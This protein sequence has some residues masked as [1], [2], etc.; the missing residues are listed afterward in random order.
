M[1]INANYKPMAYVSDGVS[2]T[3]YINFV[4]FNDE[5]EAVNEDGIKY[6]N[7]TIIRN[8][9]GKG[10]IVFGAPLEK[11]TKV[12]IRRSVPLVQSVTFN[13]GGNFPADDFEFSLDRIY[14]ILQG[15]GYDISRSI[16]L[17]EKYKDFE[18]FDKNIV[19]FPFNTQSENTPLEWD[20]SIDYQIKDICI[21][22]K[23]M[24]IN[25]TGSNK[26]T[27]PNYT[28]SGWFKCGTITYTT[29]G[30]DSM[31]SNKAD[32]DNVYTK[33][34]VDTKT[35]KFYTKTEIDNK[36]ADFYTKE[37]VDNKIGDIDSVL[38]TLNG[39]VI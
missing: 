1:T 17:P 30:I 22:D 37:E 8:S 16:V 39:E 6:E 14:M 38:D 10:S 36:V 13:E 7:Y 15:M 34:E 5:V 28:D 12:I 31:L 20:G 32:R 27:P 24:Y 29:S 23:N 33:D 25:V 18:D 35:D 2:V 21:Y 4:F 19:R 9:N 3:Y 26:G 11:G